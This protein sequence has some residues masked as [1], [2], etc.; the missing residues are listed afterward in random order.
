MIHLCLGGYFV[1]Y[2]EGTKRRI[3]RNK[4]KTQNTIVLDIKFDVYIRLLFC[5]A[6]DHRYEIIDSLDDF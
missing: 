6:H 4:E 2:M 5:N 3:F 1:S